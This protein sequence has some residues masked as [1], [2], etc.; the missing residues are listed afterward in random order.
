MKRQKLNMIG[1]S[2]IVALMLVVVGAG[3]I[4][5][6]ELVAS[7]AE[8][9]GPIVSCTT[10][11]STKKIS[12]TT[13]RVTVKQTYTNKGSGWTPT[14]IGEVSLTPWT[15]QIYYTHNI[16]ALAYPNTYSWS[17]YHDYAT[18]SGGYITANSAY[19]HSSL[20]AFIDCGSNGK[21]HVI[22]L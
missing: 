17:A 11:Y 4:G 5:T 10:T 15:Q 18:T 22:Y 21:N 9:V 1:A 20:A 6:Y 13:V 8:S 3:I 12:T 2:H 7:H 19:H 14:E 16:P